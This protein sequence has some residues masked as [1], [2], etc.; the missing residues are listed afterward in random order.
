MF[1]SHSMNAQTFRAWLLAALGNRY[2]KLAGLLVAVMLS[3]GL[4]FDWIVMPLYTSHG[5]E[6]E[7]PNVTK[8]RYEDAKQALEAEGFV[9]VNDEERFS[10][11]FPSGYIIEQNPPPHA[12]VKSGRQVYVVV[13]RGKKRV[14]MPNLVER[15]QRDAE[16][17]LARN[18]LTLG[19]VTYDYSNIHPAGVVIEQSVPHNVEITNNTRVNLVISSGPEPAQFVVPAVEGRTFSDAMRLL[20]EA[21][22]TVGQ[23][24]Y[25][26]MP[27]L[28]PETVIRQ[29][30][31]PNTVVEKGTAVDLELSALPGNNQ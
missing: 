14:L 21:G 28:L 27:D 8:M 26:I 20:Q 12:L 7:M 23:I 10:D 24:T 1:A 25:T 15:S 5:E 19:E 17:M 31:E 16:L 18:R 30:L 6:L 2:L 4:I 3:L 9:I 11:Q 13:S 22:L 29:S